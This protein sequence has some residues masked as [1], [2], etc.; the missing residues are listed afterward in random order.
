MFCSQS[1]IHRIYSVLI[2]AGDGNLPSVMTDVMKR[3]RL[4]VITGGLGP[5]IH[6]LSGLGRDGLQRFTP[7]D[8]DCC[9]VGPVGLDHSGALFARSL[10]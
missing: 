6:V 8:F 1:V 5:A 9:S 4:A 7:A 3:P 2:W 10:Q